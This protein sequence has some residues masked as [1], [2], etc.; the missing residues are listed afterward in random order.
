MSSIDPRANDLADRLVEYSRTAHPIER[1]AI[2]AAREIWVELRQMTRGKR[3]LRE[4]YTRG[5]DAWA[6]ICEAAASKRPS[7]S[8]AALP[9]RRDTRTPIAETPPSQAGAVE[10]TVS[11]G[12]AAASSNGTGEPRDRVR[13]GPRTSSLAIRPAPGGRLSRSGEQKARMI[14]ALQ[15]AATAEDPRGLIAQVR[16]CQAAWPEIGPSPWDESFA[17]TYAIAV[18]AFWRAVVRAERE[19]ILEELWVV[20]GKALAVEELALLDSAEVV[21]TDDVGLT[22]D[23]RLDEELARLV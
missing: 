20:G 8:A 10:P 11:G 4:V 3:E 1:A 9:E 13:A 19:V 2:L 23:T 21:Q 17:C 5:A 18:A 16:A 14:V 12:G 6:V 22:G 7:A 15:R